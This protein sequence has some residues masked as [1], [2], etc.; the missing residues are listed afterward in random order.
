MHNGCKW[1]V[2][3]SLLAVAGLLLSATASQAQIQK[4]WQWQ[5][6]L[7]QDHELVGQIWS[8]ADEMFIS[9]GELTDRLVSARY[10]LLGEKHDNPDHHH[11]QGAVLNYLLRAEK[12]DSVA[13]EMMDESVTD[14]LLEL[15][16]Q[17]A[18][19]AQ[20]L[21]NYLGW[22]EEGWN[23]DFYGPL[24]HS[25]YEAGMPLAAG[26]I[27]QATM[28]QIY[29]DENAIDVSG[30]LDAEAQVQMNVDIDESHCGMLPESQFPAM[31][32]V[33]QARDRAMADSLTP[34]AA[35]KLAVLIA[36][37]Y[38][39]RQDLGVPNYLAVRDADNPRSNIIALSL[40]EVQPGETNPRAYQEQIAGRPAFDYIWFTPALTD[41]D[42]CDSLEQ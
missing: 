39:V 4:P 19:S 42:Y 34:P 17:E 14:R 20:E 30:I 36:G 18:M 24:V 40:M 31:V 26:N 12:I 9:A 7:W 1:V 21:K 22:D 27:S 2:F 13:F 11:L 23:W 15:Q 5:S 25:L 8:T 10:L 32:R 6:Q 41:T 29:S 3:N 38:H 16:D 33:Q 35:G 37:N 28:G